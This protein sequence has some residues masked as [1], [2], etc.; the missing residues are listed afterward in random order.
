[1]RAPEQSL[2]RFGHWA[3]FETDAVLARQQGTAE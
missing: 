3:V 2:R 1:V